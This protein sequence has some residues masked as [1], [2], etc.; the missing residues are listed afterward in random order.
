MTPEI[1]RIRTALASGLIV[2]KALAEKAKL[3]ENTLRGATDP[4]WS[5]NAKTVRQIID[6][7]NEAGL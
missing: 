6:A 2:R 5:P 3:H 7:M 1:E 4:N